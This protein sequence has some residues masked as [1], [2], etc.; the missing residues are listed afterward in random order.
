M[1]NIGVVGYSGARFDESIAKALLILAFDIVESD[2]KSDEY[3]IVS[4]CSDMGIPGLA[5]EEADKR[6][7]ETVCFS[8]EEVK[9]YDCYDTDKE[10][11]VG[12][13]FGDESDDFIKYIDCLVRVGGGA[14]S[15]KE[16]K[17]A[18]DANKSV[19]EYDLPE[20]KK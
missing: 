4:G 7:W 12:K 19:Y 9:Q 17:M 6:G 20:I 8:A 16:T 13:E 18:K 14:Q 15:I 2:N 11:I 1:L 10:I 5:Y 3:S